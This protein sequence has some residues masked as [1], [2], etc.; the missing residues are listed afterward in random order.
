MLSSDVA[1]L[2]NFATKTINQVVKRNEIMHGGTRY[3]PYVFTKHG[4]M[5]LSGLLKSDIAA[6]VNIQIITTL[7]EIGKYKLLS[8]NI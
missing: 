1:K 4:V 2:Y 6:R 3:L 5:M 8:K 7:I